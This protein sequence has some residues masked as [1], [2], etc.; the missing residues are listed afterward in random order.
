MKAIIENNR[1]YLAM[2]PLFKIYNKDRSF[3]AYDEKERDKIIGKEF[4]IQ[5]PTITRF[6]GLGE[7]PADQL[8]NTTMN[9]VKRKLINVRIDNGKKDIKKTEGLFETLM[10]KKAELRF[11]FI[12][13]NANFIKEIDI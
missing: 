12:Q 11:K 2:P 8:K 1:L 9:M 4:K 13:D 5:S 3:Y 7:M 6:K 10:G